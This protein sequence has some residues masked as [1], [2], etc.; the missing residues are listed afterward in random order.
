M[1]FYSKTTNLLKSTALLCTLTATSASV[2][3]AAET[4]TFPARS[5]NLAPNSYWAVSEFSEG[6]CTL[7]LNVH[8]WNG[9]SWPGGNPGIENSDDYTWNVPLYSPANGR[10]ISCWRNSPDNPKQGSANKLPQVNNSANSGNGITKTIF[11]GGNHIVII[12]DE[13]NVISLNHF[14]QGSIPASLCPSNND[15]TVNVPTMA[16]EDGWRSAAY[17]EPAD[18]PRVLE[19][20]FL[21]RAGNSGNS[22]GPHLHI[23]MKRV[24]S[25]PANGREVLS[26]SSVP[27]QIRQAWA[28]RY[29]NNSPQNPE[30][31]FRQRGEGFSEAGNP[32]KKMLHPSPYLRR[33]DKS[34]GSI[35]PSMATLFM[36]SNRFVTASIGSTSNKLKLIGWDLVGVNSINRRGDIEAGAVKSVHLAKP[37]TNFVLAAVRQSNDALKMIAYH[38]TIT[39]GFQRT[40]AVYCRRNSCN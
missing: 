4:I 32:S 26:A 12:T 17:I 30:N 7:D 38:V 6:C 11:G 21:G 23:S 5:S 16:K 10:V 18:R 35:K 20:Q 31:W 1:S 24:T 8:R 3:H 13:N 22:T 25:T 39:G 33:A 27:L 37:A 40:G 36:S 2:V 15:G 34:G 14:K 28:H 29:E 9:S 19:G